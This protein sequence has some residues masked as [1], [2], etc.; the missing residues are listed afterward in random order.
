MLTAR[1]SGPVERSFGPTHKV[2]ATVRIVAAMAVRLPPHKHCLNCED[3]I[4]EDR[5]YCSEECMVQHKTRG[6]QGSRKMALFYVAAAIVLILLWVL[7]FVR[8]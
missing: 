6:K 7:T 2:K 8:F 3:P 4:P 5:D 1:R